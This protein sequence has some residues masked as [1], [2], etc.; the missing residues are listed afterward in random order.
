M[1]MKYKHI[2][3]ERSYKY[4]P[5]EKY[6]TKEELEKYLESVRRDIVTRIVLDGYRKAV[7]VIQEDK[8]QDSITLKFLISYPVDLFQK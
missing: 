4:G 7:D 3:E 2:V 1:F 8:T 6:K 5:Q